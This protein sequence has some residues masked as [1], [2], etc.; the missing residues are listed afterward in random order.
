MQSERIA[1][2]WL[3]VDGRKVR[4]LTAGD[5]APL[6]IV[7]GLGLTADFYRRN[8]VAL[9][10]ADLRVIGV[11]LPGFG[12]SEGNGALGMTVQQTADWLLSFADAARV[13]NAAWLGHSVSCQAL[14]ELAARAPDRTAA[15]ILAAPTGLRRRRRL[16]QQMLTLARDAV[17]EPIPLLRSLARDYLHTSPLRYTGTWIRAAQHDVLSSAPRVQCPTLILTGEHDPV[18]RPGIVASLI[19]ALPDARCTVIADGAHGLPVDALDRFNADVAAFLHTTMQ[20][21]EKR[22]AAPP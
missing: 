8:I 21:A 4:L 5:G 7:P 16:V 12:E 10:A 2:Q 1:Q 9:A 3:R 19:D 18:A 14:I 17:R 6:I 11:D 13:H 22:Q 15:L 20:H